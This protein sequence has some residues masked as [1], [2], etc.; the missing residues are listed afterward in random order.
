MATHLEVLKNLKI[1]KQPMYDPRYARNIEIRKILRLESG[2]R[3]P[4]IRKVANPP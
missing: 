4:T 2:C 1:R 3:T